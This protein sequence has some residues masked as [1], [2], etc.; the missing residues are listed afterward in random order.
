M[1]FTFESLLSI[2]SD[3]SIVVGDDKELIIRIEVYDSN[4][5][6]VIG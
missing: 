5:Y 3:K 4:S 1:I 6:I 2:E